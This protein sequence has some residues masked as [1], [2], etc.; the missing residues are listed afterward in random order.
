[1]ALTTRNRPMAHQPKSV[2]E[3]KA[4]SQFH[5]D[6][7][8]TPKQHKLPFQVGILYVIDGTT[9]PSNI[10]KA[11][12]RLP[13]KD[14]A[15][16]L[17]SSD[18]FRCVVLCCGVLDV[19]RPV[20]ANRRIYAPKTIHRGC[21]SL[22]PLARLEVQRQHANWLHMVARQRPRASEPQIKYRARKLATDK[23]H[24][25]RRH[26]SLPPFAMETRR[27]AL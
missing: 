15:N 19:L 14:C 26:S 27:S 4:S 8:P 25:N 3:H 12:N 16:Q 17:R 7:W 24:T 6:P 9:W 13:T 2:S 23:K 21:S 11:V 1:M 18:V 22:H 20:D 5:T 10:R